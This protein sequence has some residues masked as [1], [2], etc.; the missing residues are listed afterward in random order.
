MTNRKGPGPLRTLIRRVLDARDGDAAAT[1]ALALHLQKH[2]EDHATVHDLD[3][4]WADIGRV[5]A[6][7]LRLSRVAA[8]P[9]LIKRLLGSIA[10]PTPVVLAAG[11]AAL[12][13]VVPFATHSPPSAPSMQHYA[14]GAGARTVQLADGSTVILAPR[15]S[16]D[17]AFS[18]PTRRLTLGEGEAFFKV[19]HDAA[20]PFVV[21]TT[22]GDTRAVGTAFDVKLDGD[23]ATVTVAEGKI[24]IAGP[25]AGP[26]RYAV[27]GQQVRYSAGAAG[28]STSISD[29]VSTQDR[30]ALGWRT[31][32]LTF[33]GEP[34]AQVV[35][36]VNRYAPRAITI[37]DP[38]LARLPIFATI[39][40]DRPD[41][42]LAI[43]AA[44]AGLSP[45]QLRRALR[46]EGDG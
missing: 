37:T 26:T 16:L 9:S 14:A 15:S 10:W 12:I 46:V 44:Q 8:K 4:L 2:P 41:G 19:A 22:Y 25:G 30:N 5:P 35:A 7:E 21:A 36:Q 13:F 40:T 6:P 38:H 42:L 17:V 31:G 11:A 28:A 20:R 32:M 1:R 43:V 45:V 23:A 18:A 24:R 27:A 3:T 33:E 34:L 29:A 39:K